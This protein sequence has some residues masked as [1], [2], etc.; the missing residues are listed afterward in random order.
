MNPSLSD[1]SERLE[2]AGRILDIRKQGYTTWSCS[3]VYGP[4]GRIHV[5]LT[6]IPDPK[7]WFKNFRTSGEIVHAVANRPE[8]PYEMRETVLKGTQR[9]GDWNAWGT[10]NPRIYRVDGGYA[11][12]Y[13]VYEVPWPLEVMREH[14]GLLLSDDLSHWSPANGGGPALSPDSDPAAWDSEVVN[15]AAFV[16]DPSTRRSFLYYRGVHKLNERWGIGLAAADGVEGPYQ[17]V[18]SDPILDPLRMKNSLGGAFRG[19]E[20]PHV[21]LEGGRFRMLVKG[22]GYFPDNGG[23][24]FESV[25]GIGWNGPGHLSCELDSPFILLGKNGEPEYLYNNEPDE[26]GGRCTLYKIK[27]TGDKTARQEMP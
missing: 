8:G 19:F 9:S 22:C 27:K 1:F 26:E 5:F 15:N 10:V 2:F 17:R 7:N 13:T 11:L 23:C 12:F 16:R 6:R 20:D 14:I 21:W 24:Y 18:G 3:P 25:D 4:D